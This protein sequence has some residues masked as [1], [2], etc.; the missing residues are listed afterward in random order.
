MGDRERVGGRGGP[1]WGKA[2]MLPVPSTR[3][4]GQ[5]SR[6]CLSTELRCPPPPSSP[7]GLHPFTLPSS[8]LALYPPPHQIM[9]E[10]PV[11]WCCRV[12]AVATAHGK[13]LDHQLTMTREG[14][15]PLNATS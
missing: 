1:G 10:L 7:R 11:K 6:C 4:A 14:A 15:N 12:A 13:P 8:P 9:S 3:A 5:V 2:S